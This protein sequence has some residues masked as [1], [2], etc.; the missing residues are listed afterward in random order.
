M[1]KWEY[2]YFQTEY[3]LDNFYYTAASKEGVI[4]KTEDKAQIDDVYSYLN[5]LGAEGWEMLAVNRDSQLWVTQYH[6]LVSRP[7][8]QNRVKS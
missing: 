3:H 1:Q 2:F 4:F 6:C 5:R 8:R 7:V